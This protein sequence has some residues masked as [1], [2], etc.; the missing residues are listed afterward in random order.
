M[1]TPDP[2]VHERYADGWVVSEREGHVRHAHTGGTNGFLSSLEH[3]PE[4]DLTIVILSNL[5]F[6]NL[7][8]LS[9]AIATQALKEATERD[10]K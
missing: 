7:G 6:T 8:E 5:G 10:S 4:L 1:F 9:R 2:S 3:Y